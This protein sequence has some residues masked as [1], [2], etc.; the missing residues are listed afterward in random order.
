[1]GISTHCRIATPQNFIPKLGT[2]D[3]VHDM[4]ARANFAADLFDGC[5]PQISDM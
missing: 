4:T 5:S 3:N 1:M 2:R